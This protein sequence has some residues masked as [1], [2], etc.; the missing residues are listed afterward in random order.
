MRPFFLSCLNIRLTSLYLHHIGVD[1][2]AY[3]VARTQLAAG[4]HLVLDGHYRLPYSGTC[5]DLRTLLTTLGLDP[6]KYSEH[7]AL[8]MWGSRTRLSRIWSAE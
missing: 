8:P 5:Q 3:L 7:S 1:H 2:S 4:R 6:D